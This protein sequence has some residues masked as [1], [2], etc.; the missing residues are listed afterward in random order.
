MAD[1]DTK[2]AILDPLLLPLAARRG[3]Q[4]EDHFRAKNIPDDYI[5]SYRGRSGVE[6]VDRTASWVRFMWALACL[7]NI[8]VCQSMDVPGN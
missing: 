6:A 1:K 4:Q 8:Q 2:K 7:P 5:I 3:V